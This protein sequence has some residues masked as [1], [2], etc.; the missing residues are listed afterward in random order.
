MGH[1]RNRQ[2]SDTKQRYQAIVQGIRKRWPVGILVPIKVLRRLMVFLDLRMAD[3]R[4]QDRF[5]GWLEDDQ[6]FGEAVIERASK[7]MVRILPPAQLP[8]EEHCRIAEL[9]QK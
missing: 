2:E 8:I 4:T 1:K 3:T 5:L 7:D 6:V 9:K